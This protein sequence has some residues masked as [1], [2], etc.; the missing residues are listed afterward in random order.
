MDNEATKKDNEAIEVDYEA[1]VTSRI[2]AGQI[3]AQQTG[4]K[5]PE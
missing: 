3:K 4:N 5:I 1:I 2:G